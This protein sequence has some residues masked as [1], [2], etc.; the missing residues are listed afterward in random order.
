ML[1]FK[2]YERAA[3]QGVAAA[4]CNLGAMYHRGQGVPQDDAAAVEWYRK[5]VSR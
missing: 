2:F 3:V 1:A 4:Q 5:V